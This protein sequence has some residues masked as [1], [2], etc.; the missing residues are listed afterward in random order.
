MH[1][2]SI[3]I[4]TTTR[5]RLHRLKKHPRESFDAVIT[6]LLD[7]TIDEDPLSEETLATIERSLEEYRE[8]I[9]YTHE[10]LLRELGV[11]EDPD[12]SEIVDIADISDTSQTVRKSSK[13]NTSRTSAKTKT[14]A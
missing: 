2:T 9:Y 8:G 1:S 14:D 13:T 10:E 5:D 6:R 3:R 4:Q 12:T 11:T 7:T